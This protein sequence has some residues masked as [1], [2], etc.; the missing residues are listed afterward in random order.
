M[1][2]IARRQRAATKSKELSPDA[3]FA[4]MHRNLL[5]PS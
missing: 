5:D 4:R 3:A 1:A 2:D